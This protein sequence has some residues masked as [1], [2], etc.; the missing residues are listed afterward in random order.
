MNFQ[1]STCT[2]FIPSSKIG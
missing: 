2:G 1:D